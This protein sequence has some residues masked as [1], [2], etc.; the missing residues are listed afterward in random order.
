MKID[1][2]KSISHKLIMLL[3]IIA[4]LSTTILGFIGYNT[5]SN[6]TENEIKSADSGK[7][8]SIRV[9]IND[10]INI[11]EENLLIILQNR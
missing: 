4:I 7:M 8:S 3:A 11:Q 5:A 2:K 6:I 10:F 9:N 1:R